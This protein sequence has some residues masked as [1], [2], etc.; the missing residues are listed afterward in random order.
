MVILSLF[1]GTT[2]QFEFL[3]YHILEGE[4][5]TICIVSE[6]DIQRLVQVNVFPSSSG[7]SFMAGVFKKDIAI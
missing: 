6:A 1:A 5:K 2:L 4:V 7:K 3:S